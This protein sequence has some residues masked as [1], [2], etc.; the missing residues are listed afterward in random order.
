MIGTVTTCQK[1]KGDRRDSN[2][3]PPLEPRSADI[4]CLALPRVAKSAYLL[5]HG[6]T[7]SLRI[8]IVMVS[9]VVS[10]GIGGDHRGPPCRTEY[11]IRRDD[12]LQD[13]VHAVEVTPRHHGR[14][15][16]ITPPRHRRSTHDYR[17]SVCNAAQTA[18]I[19]HGGPG[20]VC[21]SGA[22]LGAGP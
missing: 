18:T 6:R 8:A 12:H 4:G 16:T 13:L 1:E 2:P 22:G 10:N 3:R 7:P 5:A 21:R 19:C 20:A 14:K 15:D 11:L 17:R 9:T